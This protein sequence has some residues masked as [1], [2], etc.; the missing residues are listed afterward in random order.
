MD[1]SAGPPLAG[2]TVIALEQAVAAPL[3]TRHLAD[4]GARVIK[5]ERVGEGDFARDYDDAVHGLASHFVWL[6]R[7]KESMELDLKTDAGRDVLRRL[8]ARA[9][10]FLQNLAPGAAARLGFGA[11]DLRRNNPGLVVVDMSGYGDAGPY[12]ERKAYDMLVQA[13][14]G[15]ISVTGSAD[16]A[17][18][19]GVPTSDIAAGMYALTSVLGA[20][21]RRATTGA[22]AAVA[23]SMFDATVEWMGHPLYMRLYGDRQIPR[24]GVGHAAIVPYDRY[25]TRDG[26]ILIGVQNDRG[27]RVLI[28]DVLGRPELADDPRYATNIERVRRRGEV[29]DLVAAETKR[30]TTAELDEALASAGVPAAE[31]RELDG[32]VAHPQLAER[33]RWREVGTEAGPIRAVLPPMTFA[34]VELPMGDV[35]ALGQHTQAILAELEENHR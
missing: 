15:L 7:G 29:D 9:D 27:W 12:R 2:I 8:I 35:P 6:N 4:L 30:F 20:L 28:D 33:D 1:N 21:F 26:E 22:G 17:A 18:K 5:I 23:V 19:T 3:A 13:E 34:D 25:P 32:V 16:E 10:V 31:I 14:T 24:S 11:E